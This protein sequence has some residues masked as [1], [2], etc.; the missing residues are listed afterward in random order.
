M[1]ENRIDIQPFFTYLES[2]I[3][4]TEAEEFMW[5]NIYGYK[6]K[7]IFAGLKPDPVM[8]HNLGLF[9]VDECDH[10]DERVYLWEDDLDTVMQES[11]REEY[12]WKWGY[13]MNED[14]HVRK[15]GI[16]RRLA[17]RDNHAHITYLCFD[18]GSIWPIVYLNKPFVNEMQWWL[19][20]RFFLLHGAAV[21]MN[22]KGAL[23]TSPSG[24][25]K[26]TLALACLL[27]GTEY[28]AEDYVLIAREGSPRAYPI[29]RTGYLVPKS[30]DML[31][32]LKAHVLL[33]AES[34]NKYLIDLSPY[35]DQF[36]EGLELKMII[37]PHICD[38]EEPEIVPARDARPF[39]SSLTS[40]VRQIKSQ[41]KFAPAFFALFARLNSLAGYE[42]RLCHEPRKNAEYLKHFLEQK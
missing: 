1:S 9:T 34:K 10:C 28:A 38:I 27:E 23:I 39:V 19:W 35:Q 30:L 3:D 29:F 33:Y 16:T 14:Y 36:R 4:H 8:I 21:G 6:V 24:K 31:A 18:H 5:L 20:D 32:E 25:G 42:M 12:H 37:Y 11:V 15:P 13:Q 26:S 41:Q 40:T 7:L 2:R 17:A 22:G